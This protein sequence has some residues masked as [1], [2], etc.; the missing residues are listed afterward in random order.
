MQSRQLLTVLATFYKYLNINNIYNT[1][2][3][4]CFYAKKAVN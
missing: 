1:Q 3:H 4:F 2:R